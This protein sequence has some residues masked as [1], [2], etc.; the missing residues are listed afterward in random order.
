MAILGVVYAL[1][2]CFD[3]YAALHGEGG[4]TEMPA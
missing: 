1:S 4:S 3:H 2:D